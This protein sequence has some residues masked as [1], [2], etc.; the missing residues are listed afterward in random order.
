MSRR[1]PA[2]TQI[3]EGDPRRRGSRKL[4]QALDSQPKAASGLPK[5]PP[6]LKGR[7]RATWMFLREQLELMDL[8]CAPDCLIVEGA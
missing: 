4:Q 6:H 3:R 5:C 7:A 1:K 8:D 2:K